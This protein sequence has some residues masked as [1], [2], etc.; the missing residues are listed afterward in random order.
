MLPAGTLDVHAHFLPPMY[1]DALRAAGVTLLDGCVP[2]PQW[3]PEASLRL[4]DEVGIAGA[5]LSV[6]S[7]FVA[8]FAGADADR[9]CREINNYAADLRFKH[10]S[11]FGA[12]AMLPVPNVKQSLAETERA[13]DE[14]KLDGVAL[15]TNAA[16]IYLGDSRL[17]PLLDALDERGTNVFVH[18]TSPC[19]FEA[20]GFQLPA[21]MLEFPFDT[22]RTIVSLLYSQALSRRRRINFIFAHGGGTMAFLAPRITAFGEL[23]IVGGGAIPAGEALEWIRRWFYDIVGCGSAQV[24][25]LKALVPTSQIVYG[26]DWPFATV[27]R[28]TAAATNF[29]AFPFNEAERTAVGSGNAARLF[30]TFAHRCSC[31]T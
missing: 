10:P 5:V 29:P 22:T 15:P 24:T 6:S 16:G 17:A 27:P 3:T 31:G 18:P 19:C 23:P 20:L 9:L 21:P 26:T 12:Y 14:L 1:L 7:P 4:M 13:L 11:R 2:I 30:P 28:V 25:A 8:A